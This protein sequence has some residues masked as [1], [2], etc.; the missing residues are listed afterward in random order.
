MP[1][2]RPLEI[3]RRQIRPLPRAATQPSKP[4]PPFPTNCTRSYLESSATQVPSFEESAANVICHSVKRAL[5][6]NLLSHI[7]V[8]FEGKATGETFRSM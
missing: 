3:P 6:D 5:R 4:S 7:N 1:E 2:F 8:V